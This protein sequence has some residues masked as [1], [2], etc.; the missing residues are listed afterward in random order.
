MGKAD[1]NLEYT[2][3]SKSVP[4]NCVVKGNPGRVVLRNFDNSDLINSRESG[5]DA[6]LLSA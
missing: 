1:V 4:D 5:F 3:L 2:V 6:K